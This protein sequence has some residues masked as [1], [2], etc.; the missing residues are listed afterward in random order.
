MLLEA[1][2]NFG[3]LQ[4]RQ[5]QGLEGQEQA[6]LQDPEYQKDFMQKTT[7]IFEETLNFMNMIIQFLRD[8]GPETSDISSL[9]Q[10]LAIATG[11]D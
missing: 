4:D 2:Q 5:V 11:S 10:E 3:Q 9:L 1:T 7:K 6:M 8:V